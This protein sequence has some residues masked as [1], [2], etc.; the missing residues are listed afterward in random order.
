MY[1]NKYIGII[2]IALILVIA[3]RVVLISAILPH[4]EQTRQPTPPTEAAQVYIEGELHPEIT[5]YISED[6]TALPLLQVL[7]AYGAEVE[8][9]DDD[10]AKVIFHGTY[11]L[12][13][14]DKTFVI[15]GCENNYL[16]T[17]PGDYGHSEVSG[18]DLLVDRGKM[19][20]L[21]RLFDMGT[22]RIDCDYEKKI[23]RVWIDTD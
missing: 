23:V 20:E 5:A 18:T 6:I 12:S 17:P 21:F 3:I 4:L 13:L 8:W 14:R 7:T 15:S 16:I 11:E 10:T 9:I 2:C 1:W 22:L 19:R